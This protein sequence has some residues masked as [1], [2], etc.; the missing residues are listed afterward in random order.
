MAQG[1]TVG[2]WWLSTLYPDVGFLDW[3]HD[4]HSRIFR[5]APDPEFS[6]IRPDPDLYWIL[7]C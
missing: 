3:Y 4:L 1:M 2:F 5:D 7:S 6:Y